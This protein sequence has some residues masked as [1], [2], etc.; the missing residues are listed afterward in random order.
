M[1]SV[2][3]YFQVHQPYRLTHSA[4]PGADEV[5][6]ELAPFARFD[7]AENERIVRRVAERCYLPMNQ[8][9]L[10]AIEK[11][12]GRF[13]CSFS[14]SGTVLQQLEDWAPEALASFVKLAETGRVEFLC[15][16][17]HHS[18]SALIDE[19]E[20]R[21]QVKAQRDRIEALF[22]ARPTTFRNTELIF[23][24]RIARILE[25]M[26]FDQLLG[27]G[28]DHLLQ[29]RS[30]S[31]A[32]RAHG[33]ERLKLMLRSYVYSDDIAFR[34]SN[35]EWAGYPLMADTFAGWLDEV[36]ED[37]PFI[38]LFMDYETF[39]EHQPADTGVLDFMAHLPGYILE[40]PRLDFSTPAEVAGR[41]E[42]VGDL[43]V[44]RPVSWADMERDISAWLGNPMQREAHRALYELGPK[45]RRAAEEGPAGTLLLA[46]WRRLTTS[47]HVYYMATKHHSDAEV[48]EY[49]SPFA[50]PYDAFIIF[51]NVLDDLSLRVD[52]ATISSSPGE[53]R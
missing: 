12:D 21:A 38:G 34:F 39:G 16:T 3:F 23:D 5:S 36:A 41:I 30:P 28:A 47:D 2:V 45:V 52:R 10:D 48:H 31:Y 25:E 1:T 24:N 19:T 17:S 43:D 6:A 42:P 32:Y 15:E 7:D 35:R 29:W 40:N 18:L 33:C 22:G 37:A 46:E 8:L 14:I 44:Q 50:S 9:L 11:T 27:E 4:F 13:A 26:G 20:F 51:M 49:F 53:V